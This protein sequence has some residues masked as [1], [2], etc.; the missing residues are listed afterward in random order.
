MDASQVAELVW[1]GA[2][3]IVVAVVLITRRVRRHGG[4]GRIGAVYGWL[5][6]DKKKAVEVIVEGRAAARRPENPDGRPD[7]V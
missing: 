6:E 2:A 5:N 3:L 7:D 4:A 1:T